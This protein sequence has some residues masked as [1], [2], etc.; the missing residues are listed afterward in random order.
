M[1]LTFWYA[2]K[3]RQLCHVEFHANDFAALEVALCLLL[4]QRSFI[5]HYERGR[6]MMQERR[7]EPR[8]AVSWPVRVW[9]G[10]G[11]F[12]VARAV[13]ASASGMRLTISPRA[14]A[15]IR[16]DQA[17]TIEVGF[18]TKLSCIGEVRHR[19]GGIGVQLSEP[20]PEL[21]PP[22]WPAET[23]ATVA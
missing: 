17:Y 11:L 2:I 8:R 7:S 18:P 6:S 4:W 19:T 3:A 13:D 15:M 20:L 5:C 23:Q 10:E 21:I 9:L 1:K 16:V 14:E 12:T 22:G